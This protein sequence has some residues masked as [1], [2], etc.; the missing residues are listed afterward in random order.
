MLLFSSIERTVLVSFFCVERSLPN[1]HPCHMTDDVE[2]LRLPDAVEDREEDPEGSWLTPWRSTRVAYVFLALQ[3]GLLALAI[4]LSHAWNNFFWGWVLFLPNLYTVWLVWAATLDARCPKWPVR[5]SVFLAYLT[6]FQGFFSSPFMIV[7]HAEAHNYFSQIFF[8]VSAIVGIFVV[9]RTLE[10]SRRCL[11]TQYLDEG[12]MMNASRRVLLELVAFAPLVFLVITVGAASG[13]SGVVAANEQYA[14]YTPLCTHTPLDRGQYS[15]AY[16]CIQ[17]EGGGRLENDDHIYGHLRSEV[18]LVALFV[19]SQ[20][21]LNL[22]EAQSLPPHSTTT[23]HVLMH[24]DF[25]RFKAVEDYEE[26]ASAFAVAFVQGIVLVYSLLVSLVLNRGARISMEDLLRWRLTKAE[27]GAVVCTGTN[28]MLV[29]LLGSLRGKD[30]ADGTQLIIFFIMVANIILQL[31]F[32]NKLCHDILRGKHSF[33]KTRA[34]RM[35]TVAVA[36][37]PVES[38]DTINAS[39]AEGSD[40]GT[41]RSNSSSARPSIGP[42]VSVTDSQERKETIVPKKVAASE[43]AVAL[44]TQQ[45]AAKDGRTHEVHNPEHPSAS[46][47]KD[48]DE[49]TT[50]STQHEHRWLDDEGLPPHMYMW[51]K[52]ALTSMMEAHTSKVQ[53]I[54]EA[55]KDE[56]KKEMLESR[57]EA[58]RVSLMLEPRSSGES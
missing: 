8:S 51:S 38:K 24:H 6:N 22:A 34:P 41:I 42:I 45:L 20:T 7:D 44:P 11:Q 36:P 25:Q 16:R 19:D 4:G 50:S 54:L 40:P 27:L 5:V 32:L 43:K 23:T 49:V 33:H 15:T 1:Q 18:A 57:K 48:D 47:D 21:H 13:V 9:V 3:Q 2:V 10:A 28:V 39:P 30:L 56:W 52:D 12:K 17:E 35:S 14:Q 31:G 55:F 26:A 37:Q 46:V 29:L 53:V 58:E